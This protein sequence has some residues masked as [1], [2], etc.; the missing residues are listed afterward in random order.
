MPL[1]ER[2][3]TEQNYSNAQIQKVS[4]GPMALPYKQMID[5]HVGATIARPY[6]FSEK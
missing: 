6:V 4:G 2:K 5:I 1:P 3:D